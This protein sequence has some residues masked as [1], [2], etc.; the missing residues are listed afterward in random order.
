MLGLSE[1][2][3]QLHH[4][5][6]LDW[7][8]FL[9]GR[10]D[11]SHEAT[12]QIMVAITG[13]I[14]NANNELLNG[15][16]WVQLDAPLKDASTNPDSVLLPVLK[17][18]TITAGNLSLNLPESESQRVSYWFRF[19]EYEENTTT[20][21]VLPALEFRSF[22]PNLASVEFD[23]LIP[24]NISIDTIGI[25]AAQIA[26][27]L[28]TTSQYAEILRGDPRYTGDYS[29]T[30]IYKRGEAARYAGSWWMWFV[31]D[32]LSGIEP[33]TV[34]PGSNY[35]VI[36]SQ[37][38]DPGGTGGQDTV[39]GAGWNGAT[40]AP[41]ANVLYDIISTLATVSSL[42]SYAPLASP[43]FTGNPGRNSALAAGDNSN[44]FATSAWVR[45]LFAPLASPALTGN[46]T[47][48][49]QLTSDESTKLA[50]TQYV[51]SK[52]DE[53]SQQTLIIASRANNSNQ[54]LALNAFSSAI[55]FSTEHHD[56]SNLYN[57][58]TGVFTVPTTAWYKIVVSAYAQNSANITTFN[59]HLFANGV[60]NQL[61]GYG[62]RG[63]AT[64]AGMNTSAIVQLT[65]SVNY[66]IRLFVASASGSP[67]ITPG[68]S[69]ETPCRFTLERLTPL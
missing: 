1:Y 47:A 5:K 62:D 27:I 37:K 32:Q 56:P 46:P 50:T 13:L 36:V 2:T 11:R 34:A 64:D 45:S 69:G 61:I 51:R 21:K 6:R 16:L 44:L 25:N 48:P 3:R 40:W 52:L 12:L 43:T 39:Y 10:D 60:N 22:V 41:T 20:P 55:V 53:R 19:F 8:R 57:P 14:R 17:K 31:D 63:Q 33:S 30:R 54:A 9:F 28:A 29:N 38:G 42:S 65:S 4:T 15:Q 7:G 26:Q 59:A 23:D 66:D 35:W 24:V 68:A 58:A 18:I 49:T 67:A